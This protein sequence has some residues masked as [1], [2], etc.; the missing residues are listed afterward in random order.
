MSFIQRVLSTVTGIFVFLIICFLCLVVLG[1]ILGSGSDDL[2]KVKSNSVLEL[3]LDFPIKDYGGKIEFKEYPFL[4]E[5]SKKGLFNIIDAIDYAATDP[6]IKGISIDNNFINAGISQTKAL[7]GALLKFKE[8]GKFVVAYGDM[9][10][11][12][13]YYLSSVADTIYVNP[14]GMLE[15]KGL[16]TEQLYFKD[17]QEKTGFKMEI[18]RH[19]K[20]KSAVEPFLENEMSDN[21]RVQIEAYLKSLWLEIRKDISISRNISVERLN[22]I[23]DSLLARNPE[24]AKSSNLIDKVAYHDEYINAMKFAIG[25]DSKKELNRISMED[26]SEYASRHMGGKYNKN[27]IAVIYA[28]GDI[29]YGEGDENTVGQGTMEKSLLEA[30]TNPNIKA[31]VLRVN[32]PG[33]SA[34]ASELIWREIELTKKVKPVI[35]SMGNYAASGGYYIASNAHKIIAE[36]TTITGS[37]G[38]FGMLPNGKQLAENMGINAEQVITNQNALTYSFFEPLSDKQRKY[39]KEGVVNVYELFTNRVAQGRKLTK[40][41]VEEIAQGRVWTGVDALK[42][43]LVDELGGLDL[44]L[45]YAAEAAEL[46]EYSIR[47]F[48]VFEKDL[49]KMLEDFGIVKAKETILNEEL[50]EENYKILKEIKSMSQKNGVQLL[51]PYS[52]NI[53]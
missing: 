47:E 16:S 1:A 35:V 28:E 22:T 53:K 6:N 24:L 12:K 44:A 8:S 26:Y 36:P 34:L 15:F 40:A 27:K 45:K 17:F 11:Q 46:Q 43:G 3:T 31:V 30:R 21:N 13:D 7:R 37:I 42:I 38:V 5:S 19:G 2:V 23:A 25:L 32:S 10:S 20:Y 9:Y 33:G 39:I 29:I 52:T 50:G 51:F 18:V 14:A 48:P 41:Q 49:D 4:N